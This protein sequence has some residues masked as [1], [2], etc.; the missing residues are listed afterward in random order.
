MDEN[1]RKVMFSNKS[2][3]YETPLEL[4]NALHEIFEFTLDPAA[5]ELSHMVDNYYTLEDDGLSKSWAGETCFINPPYSKARQ[6]IEAATEEYVTSGVTSVMLLAA[7]TETKYW[8][9]NIWPHAAYIV[10]LKGRLKFE[11]RIIEEKPSSA[12]Y[13][14]A[15][16]IF[17][18]RVLRAVEMYRLEKLGKLIVL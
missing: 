7:R 18:N 16:I 14:S 13:P 17:T 9:E 4:F 11:N 12:P 8:H 15:I 2:D 3:E 1:T 6:W 5:S 10:F